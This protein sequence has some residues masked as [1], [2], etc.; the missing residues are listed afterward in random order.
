MSDQAHYWSKSAARYEDEFVD[1]YRRPEDNPLLDAIANVSDAAAKTVADLGCGVGPLVPTLAVHFG[2]VV[3][4]DFAAGMLDRARERCAGLTN[5]EFMQRDLG[6]LAPLAGSVDVAVAVN[7][8]VMPSVAA[9]EAVLRQVRSILRP[10][11]VFFGIVPAIDAVHYQ[12]MLLVNRALAAGMPEPAARQNAAAQA[13]HSLYDF[14]FGGFRYI[15]L[16]QHFWQPFEI[17]YRL[18]RAGFRRVRKAKV[19]LDLSQ[20]ACASDLKAYPAPWDWFFRAEV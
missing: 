6:D 17:G 7:S 18:R 14:A 10:G 12:T 3:A 2:S 19:R 20:F 13:E 16:E 4:V 8:L 5:V 15:G 11:G 1:P 9:I